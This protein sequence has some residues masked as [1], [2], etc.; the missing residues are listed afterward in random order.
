MRI[1]LRNGLLAAAL[2]VMPASASSQCGMDMGGGSGH[3]HGQMEG[4]HEQHESKAR[5]DVDQ[6]AKKNAKKLLD[7]PRGQDALLEAI[8]ENAEFTRILVATLLLEPE[9][10][11][12]MSEGL[13]TNPKDTVGASKV[14]DGPMVSPERAAK[15]TYRCPMH[16]D[17]ISDQ[18]GKCPKCG[19]ELERVQKGTDK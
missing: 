2:M 15:A 1:G 17:V 7:D 10:R 13:S 14:D 8:L 6:K 12:L 11:A 3:D 5:T 4:T 16:A 19:M 9:W 18:P